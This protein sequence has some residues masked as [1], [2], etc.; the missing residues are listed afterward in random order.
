MVR[1]TALVVVFELQATQIATTATGHRNRPNHKY[2]ED[3]KAQNS[4]NG[5]AGGLL[6]DGADPPRSMST[7]VWS[8]LYWKKASLDSRA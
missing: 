8:Y 5:K 2:C 1:L 3:V 4:C 6:A 7:R